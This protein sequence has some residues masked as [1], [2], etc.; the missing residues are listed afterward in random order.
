MDLYCISEQFCR[1]VL[2]DT[3]TR[4]KFLLVWYDT[5]VKCTENVYAHSDTAR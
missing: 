2:A 4:K 1:N 3:S 5:Y